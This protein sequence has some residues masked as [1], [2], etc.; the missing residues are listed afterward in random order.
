MQRAITDFELKIKKAEVYNYVN[1]NISI[2]ISIRDSCMGELETKNIFHKGFAGKLETKNS[3][4][5]VLRELHVSC[6]FQ[7]IADLLHGHDIDQLNK[8]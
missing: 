7:R 8:H 6:N 4:N 2:K 5:E 3:D 1:F